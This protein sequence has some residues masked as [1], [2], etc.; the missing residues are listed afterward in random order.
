MFRFPCYDAAMPIGP[1]D[2]LIILVVLVLF[3]GARK[4]P[5]IGRSLGIGVRGFKEEITGRSEDDM[6]EPRP[7]GEIEPL[8][9]AEAVERTK[10]AP[11]AR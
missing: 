2:L 8:A 1:W 10:R 11:A 4:L 5:D 6:R 3:F 7:V 9:E